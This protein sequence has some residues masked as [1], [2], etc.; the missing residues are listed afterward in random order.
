[1]TYRV[2]PA[3]LSFAFLLAPC[4]TDSPVSAAS[5]PEFPCGLLRPSGVDHTLG[6]RGRTLLTLQRIHERE[7]NAMYPILAL[8]GIMLLTWGVTVWASIREEKP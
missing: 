5:T 7:V 6:V 3:V 1:M 8:L 2:T 4:A